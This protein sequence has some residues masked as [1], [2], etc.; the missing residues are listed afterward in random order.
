MIIFS[1]LK[2]PHTQFLCPYYQV[3]IFPHP[4]VLSESFLMSQVEIQETIAISMYLLLLPMYNVKESA[5][6]HG[7]WGRTL[8]VYNFLFTDT[9]LITHD[10]A[11]FI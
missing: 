7:L 3:M 10:T 11:A 4:L 6:H 2:L 8:P 9:P 1:C 5:L